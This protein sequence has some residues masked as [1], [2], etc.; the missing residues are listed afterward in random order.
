MCQYILSLCCVAC[1]KKKHEVYIV[2]KRIKL[3]KA[4]I[5]LKCKKKNV[6]L[7]SKLNQNTNEIIQFYEKKKK[8]KKTMRDFIYCKKIRIVP[9]HVAIK[10][11]DR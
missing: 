10:G 2:I 4:I 1:K 3:L 11:N 5:C 9:F 6:L 7:Y 8:I